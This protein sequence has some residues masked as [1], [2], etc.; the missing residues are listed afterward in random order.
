MATALARPISFTDIGLN[1]QDQDG[2]SAL[3]ELDRGEWWLG[4]SI[5]NTI[6]LIVVYGTVLG[7]CPIV[8]EFDPDSRQLLSER[9]SVLSLTLAELYG[10]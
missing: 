9:G 2:N 10:L 7:S 1:D 4:Y 8:C 3:L 5:T 6:I